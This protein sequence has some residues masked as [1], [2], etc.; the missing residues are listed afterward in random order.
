[1]RGKFMSK[2]SWIRPA[3]VVLLALVIAA[4]YSLPQA[5]SFAA[6]GSGAGAGSAAG[7]KATAKADAGVVSDPYGKQ[8]AADYYKDGAFKCDNSKVSISQNTGG[9][10]ILIKGQK[11]DLTSARYTFGG[12][13]DFSG[14][15]VGR[16][17]VDALGERKA[18]FTLDFYL[19]GSSEP[20]A[21]VK[22]KNQNRED[23]WTKAADI[24]TDTLG[25]NIVGKHTLSFKVRD[26]RDDSGNKESFLLRSVEFV[27]SS[28]PTLYFNID[29]SQGTISDMNSDG[30]HQTECFGDMTMQVPAGYYDEYSGK[31]Q[32]ADSSST[33]SL[34]YIRGRG[35]STWDAD[36]KPY[37]VKFDKKQN[38]LSMGTSKNWVL[39]ANR[40]DNSLLRNKLTYWLGGQLGMAYTPKCQFVDVVMN[41]TYYGSYYLST[42]VRVDKNSV[43]I[44]D[45]TDKTSSSATTEPTITGGYLLS[46]GSA[47]DEKTK[48]PTSTKRDFTT[49]KGNRFLIESPDF[50]GYTNDAQYNYIKDYF[51]KTEDAIYG[52]DFKESSGASYKDYMDVDSAVDYYWLQEISYNGDAF[53]SNST[54][55]YKARN[56]KLCWGPL[57]DFDFVAWGDLEYGKNM[58]T[59][60]FSQNQNVWYGRLFEDKT[61]S[62]KVVDRWPV[63][64]AKLEELT[65]DGGQLDKYVAQVGISE[66][67]DMEKWGTYAMDI[68][69]DTTVKG[70]RPYSEEVTQLKTW[71]N[72]RV[73]WIDANYKTLQLKEYKVKFVNGKKTVKTITAYSQRVITGFPKNPAKKGY[74]FKGW[75]YNNGG[76]MIKLTKDTVATSSLTAHA[77]WKKIRSGKADSSK[78][79]AIYFLNKKSFAGVAGVVSDNPYTAVPFSA[80]TSGMKWKSSNPAVATVDSD[81]NIEA[82]AKG[83]T[84]I[85]LTIGKASAS[86]TL[87]V[88]DIDSAVVGPYIELTHKSMKVKVGSYGKINIKTDALYPIYTGLKFVSSDNSIATVSSAGVVRGKKK[89]KAVILLV[90]STNTEVYKC[91][92]TVR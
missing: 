67:Y 26:D 85:S 68:D 72:K 43:N 4:A 11:G 33:Y 60:E 81:G 54:Y 63:I 7:T 58:N 48:D 3:F 55:L 20:F 84:V 22:I 86:Y 31:T 24:T 38:L 27:Q 51:Q 10:G 76:S 92:V 40:F 35:N 13:F 46:M 50:E 87:K 45:L 41:G 78:I 5:Q 70:N 15:K 16:F 8:S 90:D 37:K 29:E 57:W 82:L 23:F 42:Q 66:K 83:K 6:T 32:A 21:S 79:K 53:G 12:Q 34:D 9:N 74:E 25:K 52:K 59:T 17:T 62:K 56:G 18:K 30:S 61:F 39:L 47:D 71:I 89:G 65:R 44:D 36:K 88:V 14:N 28:L 19:D 69:G 80:D 64:K 75:Y 49:K 1:M 77:K 91:K 2:K 73:A